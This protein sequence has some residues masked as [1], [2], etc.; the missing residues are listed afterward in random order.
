VKR[1][2]II[3]FYVASL[4]GCVSLD[5]ER[6]IVP[7]PDT[8]KL[9]SGDKVGVINTL[10]A[11]PTHSNFGFLVFEN[12]QKQIETDWDVRGALQTD[13]VSALE[14]LGAE[15]VILNENDFDV[16][17]I[18]S[19]VIPKD[20]EFHIKKPK[21]ISK[22]KDDFGLRALIVLTELDYA[23][24]YGVPLESSFEVK[25]YGLFTTGRKDSLSIRMVGSF[26]IEAFHFSPTVSS[27]LELPKGNSYPSMLEPE[28]ASLNDT[29]NLTDQLEIIDLKNISK[30][31]MD[32]AKDKMIRFVEKNGEAWQRAINYT[33]GEK[34]N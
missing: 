13:V 20:G 23:L 31:E 15:V 24:L 1:F 30:V 16:D 9:N 17:E 3:I 4:S 26:G 12:F 27:G 14:L 7:L 34:S 32:A 19:M 6:Y 10:R 25:H 11:N 5:I 21:L 18:L 28:T 8:V 33:F 29:Y 2:F 22:F